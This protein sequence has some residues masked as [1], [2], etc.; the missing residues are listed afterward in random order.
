MTKYSNILVIGACYLLFIWDLSF[1]IWCFPRLGSDL[2]LP[3][4][5]APADDQEPDGARYHKKKADPH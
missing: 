3:L 2:L 5:D 1:R 4:S